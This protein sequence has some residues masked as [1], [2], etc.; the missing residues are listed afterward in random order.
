MAA[1]AS[2]NFILIFHG[3]GNFLEVY[4]IYKKNYQKTGTLGYLLKYAPHPCYDTRWLSLKMHGYM[5]GR[6]V[7]RQLWQTGFSDEFK[8]YWKLEHN[9]AIQSWMGIVLK[10]FKIEIVLKYQEKS[11]IWLVTIKDWNR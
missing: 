8:I 4:H 6:W 1:S 9:F 7:G 3:A 10:Y 2:V 5:K 11:K